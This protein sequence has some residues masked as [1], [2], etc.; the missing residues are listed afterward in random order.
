MAGRVGAAIK[1]LL[2]FSALGLLVWALFN[3]QALIDLWRIQTYQPPAAISTLAD[4]AG[5][6]THARQLFYASQ[7]TISDAATFNTQ[8]TNA[9]EESIV[10]GCYKAQSIYLFDVTDARFNGVEE[11]T[12][13]H[14]MLHAAYERLPPGEKS[15]VN[16]LV[17]TQ[18]QAITDERILGLVE[19]YNKQEPGELLNEMHAI[20]G[21]EYRTLSPELEA[22]FTRYFVDRAKVVSLSE[23]YE[24]MLLAAKNRIASLDGQLEALRGQID[25]NNATLEARQVELNV[26][27]DRLE[28]L[29]QQDPPQYNQAVPG[30]NARVRSFNALVAQT[31]AQVAEFNRLVAERNQQVGLQNSLY[32]SLNSRYQAVPQN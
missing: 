29:R 28:A 9:T 15:R 17:E 31:E 24:G 27:A 14:E 7:P 19:L 16:G 18:L 2:S 10:L 11:V 25:A 5:F 26:E 32:Q 22:Y 8:C 13:A 6:T 1:L 23:G 4:N 30:F 12:A 21:T 3:Q 20:L